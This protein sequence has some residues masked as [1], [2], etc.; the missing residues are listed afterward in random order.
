MTT[1]PAMMATPAA[2]KG[3]T[4]T[5][6]PYEALCPGHTSTTLLKQYGATLTE[7][8]IHHAHAKSVLQL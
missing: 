8:G 1:A 6:V 2:P 5:L 7:A 4:Q 3:A